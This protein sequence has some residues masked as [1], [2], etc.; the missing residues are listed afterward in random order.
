MPNTIEVFCAY[1]RADEA[2]RDQL[3]R[4][5]SPFKRLHSIE[6]WHD[7]QIEPGTEWEEDIAEDLNSDHLILLLISSDFLDSTYCYDNELKRAMERHSANEA[8]VIPIILRDCDWHVLPIAKLQVLPKDG[9]A[10]HGSNWKYID[11]AFADIARG[12]RNAV[13]VLTV[14]RP[15]KASRPPTSVAIQ[16]VGTIGEG[17][18]VPPVSRRVSPI[19]DLRPLPPHMFTGTVTIAHSRARNGTVIR[20]L[21]DGVQVPGAYATVNG[22]KYEVV[23]IVRTAIRPK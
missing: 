15:L 21:I 6:V 7:R 18:I 22:G 5:L 23:P 3:D 17:P 12:V 4:H 14:A 13:Q 20:A 2:L 10:S 16:I 19:P 8:R 11:E 9:K 1:A